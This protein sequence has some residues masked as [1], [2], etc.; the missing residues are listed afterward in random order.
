MFDRNKYNSSIGC[1]D[2]LF[3]ILVGFAF[4]FIVAFLLIKPEAKKEDFERKAEFVV[5]MEW[6]HDAPDD[7][8]LYVQDPT[9]TKVHFRL[10]ITNF[11]YLDKDDL[12]FAND[13]VKNVDGTITK[14]N[15]NRE[16]VTIR[17]IIPGEYIINA[18]YYSARQWEN[19]GR[20]NT[21]HERSKPDPGRKLTVKVELH[22][23]NP[24][25]IWW[26]GEKT[27][28]H[29]GQEETFVRF[30]LDHEGNQVG[31]F[32]YIEKDFVAPFQNTVGSAAP[33][34]FEQIGDQ[35][36]DHHADEPTGSSTLVESGTDEAD[37]LDSI[38]QR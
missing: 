2:M 10:P 7:V 23:V 9:G 36:E 15:I 20:L 18:H 33:V 12:G 29:R 19:D 38:R 1:T 16:V 21:N 11:M 22:R 31:D 6:N 14:V 35:I 4:L 26:V 32:N 3:N 27:F 37:Y 25:K 17:G 24:Y 34:E 5:V 28:T 8:D 30:T 13:I